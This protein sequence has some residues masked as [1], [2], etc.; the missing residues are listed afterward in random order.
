ML[1]L[2]F[3]ARVSRRYTR[4]NDLVINDLV[5]A[6]FIVATFVSIICDCFRCEFLLLST[7]HRGGYCDSYC[8]ICL[9]LCLRNNSK[10]VDIFGWSRSCYRQFQVNLQGAV[11]YCGG[12]PH[13]FNKLCGRPPQ[14]ATAP[15]KLTFDL[16]TLKMVSESR[17]TWAI[18]VPISVFLGLSVKTD[19]LLNVY[20][21]VL[22]LHRNTLSYQN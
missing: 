21:T 9:Y 16:L 10:A 15:C 14:Y 7:R 8:L 19:S 11:A 2:R 12:L 17:V 18:S 6:V 5:I 22:K 4:R 3:F 1:L 13:S 20:F